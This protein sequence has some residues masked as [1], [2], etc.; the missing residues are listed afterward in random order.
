MTFTKSFP[1]K[2]NKSVYPNWEEIVLTEEEE[3]LIMQKA[4]NENI[5]LMKECIDD[6]KKL[7]S[8]KNLKDFQSDIIH[9]AISLFEKRSSHEI[10]YK[11]NL[12]K[13]KFDRISKD[14]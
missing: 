3:K 12:A 4:R 5:G 9:T 11:E 10:F 7:F 13:E 8:D 2:S 14:E 1:K 6:A